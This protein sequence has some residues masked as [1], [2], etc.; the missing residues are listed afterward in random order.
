MAHV[1][2]NYGNLGGNWKDVSYL[3]KRIKR[4]IFVPLYGTTG[5]EN[6]LAT[7]AGVTKAAL[8]AL[9]VAADARNR[10]YPTPILY[11]VENPE[12]DPKFFDWDDGTQDFIRRGSIKFKAFIKVQDG[13]P[14]LA[15]RLMDA[16]NG[17]EFGVFAIDENKNFIYNL[18][19]AGTILKPIPVEPGSFFARYL[20]T[21]GADDVGK[22][23]ISFTLKG[24]FDSGRFRYVKHESLDFDGLSTTDMY[25]LWNVTITQ[26]AKS[27]TTLTVLIKTD[28]NIPVSG[29]AKT[30]MYLYNSTDP[31]VVSITTAPESASIPG[32][33]ALTF[34]A[35]T[36]ADAYSFNLLAASK[37]DPADTLTG[38]F[39]A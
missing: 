21:P 24:E 32:Q 17:A 25:S 18:D 1:L 39:N 11:N 29:L 2:K 33:Y 31:A 8:Q 36:E 20:V 37:Y 9:F 4:L 14:A 13:G 5:A 26:V 30:D 34:G 23:E 7:E 22:V 27:L 16:W 6:T 28:Y 15:K 10:Y 35:Q 12:E 3:Q 19:S 38:T